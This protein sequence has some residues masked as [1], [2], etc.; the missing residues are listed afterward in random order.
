MRLPELHFRQYSNDVISHQH[1]GQWQ[2]VLSLSG[3]MEINMYRQH[4]LLN[5]GK[6]VVI[7]PSVSHAFSGQLGN[8]NYVLEMPATAQWALNEK[9]TQF[10]LTPAAIGL[11]NWLQ[12][13][14]QA[15]EHNFT[16]AR[17]L[18]AQLKPE[19]K[20]IDELSQWVELRL[21][22]PISCE[23][24][25]TA[26]C[27]SV[28][29]LQRKI[30]AETQLTAMQFLLQKRMEAAGRLLLSNKSIEQI[31]LAV[32]YDSHSAF[33]HAFRQFYSKT[34]NE[35]RLQGSHLR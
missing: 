34:P 7:P 25:A 10:T 6:G 4:F 11:L 18:L 35:Y 29:T 26:F 21:H 31:A 15:L 9:M 3:Q 8:Q 1:D 22:H 14:P 13:F 30:K 16:V 19:N 2:V 20:W 28:S 32:G 5:A 33:S 12:N 23:D 27:M 24:M 17:L